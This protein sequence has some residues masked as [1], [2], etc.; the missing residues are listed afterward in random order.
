MIISDL[1]LAATR[2]NIMQSPKS[3]QKKAYVQKNRINF[4]DGIKGL[5]NLP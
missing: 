5:A 2:Q 4:R 3:E 1:G